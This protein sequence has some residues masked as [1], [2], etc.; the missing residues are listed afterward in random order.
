MKKYQKCFYTAEQKKW[1]EDYE[2]HTTFEP[3]MEEYEAGNTTFVEAAIWNVSWFE[4]WA[5]DAHLRAGK[6][7]PGM[8]EHVCTD[9]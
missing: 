6:G 4:S 3:V 5:S 7:I 2:R 9:A 8:Y 1:C